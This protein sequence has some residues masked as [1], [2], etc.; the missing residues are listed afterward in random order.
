MEYFDWKFCQLAFS[1]S[2]GPNLMPRF[3][4]PWLEISFHGGP[5]DNGDFVL[6]KG[7]ILQI[8]ARYMGLKTTFA[9]PNYPWQ[10]TFKY[11]S[12]KIIFIFLKYTLTCTCFLCEILLCAFFDG[13]L[14]ICFY[15]FPHQSWPSISFSLYT[16]LTIHFFNKNWTKRL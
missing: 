1:S 2:G 13:D 14:I 3:N 10:R 12:S 7:C 5:Q 4:G 11:V 16:I 15:N 9:S 6:I 8:R